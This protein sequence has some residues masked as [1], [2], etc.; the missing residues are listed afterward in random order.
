MSEVI[1]ACL[2]C[3][4][5]LDFPLDGELDDPTVL[6]DGQGLCE[7]CQQPE[8]PLAS[9]NTLPTGPGDADAAAAA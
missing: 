4:L 9:V 8:Q 1:D 6:W 2:S 7:H 5:S 3:G